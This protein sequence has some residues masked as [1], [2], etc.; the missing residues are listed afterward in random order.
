M[1]KSYYNTTH[2]MDPRPG[3]S[4]KTTYYKQSLDDRMKTAKHIKGV[5]RDVD[6]LPMS[7]IEQ[8]LHSPIKGHKKKTTG[9]GNY[10]VLDVLKDALAEANG[11]QKNGLPKDFAKAPIDRWNKVFE[12]LESCT[13][14]MTPADEKSEYN[15]L[16]GE[17]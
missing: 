11:K 3:V 4:Y 15:N 6:S 17:L 12:D 16:F 2:E 5:L 1:A 7:E 10:T 9:K 8:W 14:E 13:I